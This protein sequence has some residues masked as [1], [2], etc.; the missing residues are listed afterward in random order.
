MSRKTRR[1]PRVYLPDPR[2]QENPWVIRQPAGFYPRVAD[3]PPRPTR[4]DTGWPF[5]LEKTRGSDTGVSAGILVER[6]NSGRRCLTA[7]DR[8]SLTLGGTM[9]SISSCDDAGI[10]GALSVR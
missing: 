7:D 2:G 6:S 8:E 4:A 9:S 10:R 5:E 1:Y 3:N